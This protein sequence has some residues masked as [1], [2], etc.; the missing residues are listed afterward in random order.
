MAIYYESER[1][2]WVMAGHNT[3]KS[4]TYECTRKTSKR[5]H[6]YCVK[7][8]SAGGGIP[9]ARRPGHAQ[10]HGHR[11]GHDCRVRVLL[12]GHAVQDL[13]PVGHSAAI[14]FP[15]PD[16]LLTTGRATRFPR[17]RHSSQRLAQKWRHEIAAWHANPA[18]GQH[19]IDPAGWS[20]MTDRTRPQDR[21]HRHENGE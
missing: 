10:R 21:G 7:V 19:Y 3:H 16:S 18:T 13:A 15:P 6:N 2:L 1:A 9:A 5:K 12:L 8:V 20:A 14:H 4:I 17:W 11:F